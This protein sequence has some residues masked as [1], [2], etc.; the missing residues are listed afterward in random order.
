M[1]YDK[2]REFIQQ[3][4]KSL[5]PAYELIYH[6][7]MTQSRLIRNDEDLKPLC[8]ENKRFLRMEIREISPDELF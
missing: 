4:F 5:P 7:S 8:A 2:L 1:S 3:K 6:E